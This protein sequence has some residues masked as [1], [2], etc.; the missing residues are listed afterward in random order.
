[1]NRLDRLLAHCR[2][3]T[4]TLAQLTPTTTEPCLIGLCDSS[5]PL[6]SLLQRQ[7]SL[8]LTLH[9]TP[10]ASLVDEALLSQRLNDIFTLANRSFYIVPFSKVSPGLRE[11]YAAACALMFHHGVLKA[12][13]AGWTEA[14]V[15]G[16]VAVVDRGLVVAGGPGSIV[17]DAWAREALTLLEEVWGLESKEDTGMERKTNSELN[18]H[19]PRW[20]KKAQT[21]TKPAIAPTRPIPRLAS[22][23][24][25]EFQSHL[26]TTDTPLIFT[27]MIDNWPAL[28]P[29]PWASVDYLLGKTFAGK[30]LVPVEIGRSYVDD[31]WG[32]TLIPFGEFVTRWMD[33]EE[34]EERIGYLAQHNLFSHIPALAN[35]IMT[36]DLCFVDIPNTTCDTPK[37]AM[38]LRN[39]WYGPRGTITPL[40]TDPYANLLCQV[41]GQK[42]VRLYAP[43]LGAEM[44]VRGV[45]DGVDMGNTAGWDVGVLQGW[46]DG[47]MNDKEECERLRRLDYLDCV[48]GPGDVLY[49]PVGWWHYCR[50]LSVSFSVSFWWN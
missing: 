22:M 6:V 19:V 2:Q 35:D 37:L 39:A 32:Q 5:F 38:P 10:H 17:G 1:M 21:D 12:V 7:A 11:M 15:D 50:G 47:E 16:L 14:V 28:G 30:R 31:G 25:S 41:V 23:D 13:R 20:A 45:E 46:D 27:N 42:Y 8:V 3:A 4:A 9:D 43:S 24:L 40:H 26:H 18:L 33:D 44:R 29:S 36:P 34:S 48:L 49:I